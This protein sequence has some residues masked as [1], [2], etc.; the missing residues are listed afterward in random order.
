MNQVIL[1]GKIA[2]IKFNGFDLKIPDSVKNE[3]G[4]YGYTIVPVELKG[5]MLDYIKNNNIEL[6]KI[7]GVKGRI[8]NNFG[9]VSVEAQK[10][11]FLA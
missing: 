11:S 10:I 3:N 4:E 9:L 7:V 1:V 6:D 8:Q 5:A 2:E